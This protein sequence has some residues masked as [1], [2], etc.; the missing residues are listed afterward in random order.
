MMP[1][2]YNIYY[3]H[4]HS[5]MDVAVCAALMRPSCRAQ[6]T[7]SEKTQ[8]NPHNP[9]FPQTSFDGIHVSFPAPPP[10]SRPMRAKHTVPKGVQLHKG[11]GALQM[12]H[13]S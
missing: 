3:N 1:S 9:P 6:K 12:G 11:G 13:T 4:T 10:R 5:T 7:G 2:L 8:K